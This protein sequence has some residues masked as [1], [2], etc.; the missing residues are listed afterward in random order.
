MCQVTRIGLCTHTHRHLGGCEELNFL[1]LKLKK[2]ESFEFAECWSSTSLLFFLRKEQR[3]RLSW[4]FCLQYMC[5]KGHFNSRDLWAQRREQTVTPLICQK[6]HWFRQRSKPVVT[7]KQ[8]WHQSKCISMQTGKF[9]KF[10]SFSF[11][12]LFLSFIFRISLTGNEFHTKRSRYFLCRPA[13]GMCSPC[14]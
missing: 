6:G 8:T 13:R 11:V 10:N 14:V 5:N 4:K 2:E 3:D 7:E 9:N 12:S 1:S